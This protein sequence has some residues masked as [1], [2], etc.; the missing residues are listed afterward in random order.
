MDDGVSRLYFTL[1]PHH[2][3]LIIPDVTIYL[4]WIAPDR[5]FCRHVSGIGCFDL[6]QTDSY[7]SSLRGALRFELSCCSS[8]LRSLVHLWGRKFA[9]SMMLLGCFYIED[10]W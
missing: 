4:S 5:C 1:Y 2:H 9:E 10:A 3:R 8:V 6:F 7:L